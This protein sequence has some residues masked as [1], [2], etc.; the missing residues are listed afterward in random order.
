MTPQ[1]TSLFDLRD[2]VAERLLREMNPW[3]QGLGVP[4]LQP[5]KRWAFEPLLRGLR[6]QLAPVVVLRG[7]RQV[8]KST[9]LAQV[10]EELLAGGVEPQRI[11]R[12][13]FDDLKLLRRHGQPIL[14]IV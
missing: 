6:S 8:G 13:Q 2:P 12:V 14:E 4:Q 3:W 11:L 1:Q 7:P 10:I 5:V 9:L